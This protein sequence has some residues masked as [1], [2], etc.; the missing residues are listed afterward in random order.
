MSGRDIAFAA[1]T[2]PGRRLGG[3]AAPRTGRHTDEDRGGPGNFLG[4]LDPGRLP[5]R[6]PGA[7]LCGRCGYR[8]AGNCTLPA[9]QGRGPGGGG[10]GRRRALC[11]AGSL[12][13]PGRRQR[14]GQGDCPDLRCGGGDHHRHGSPARLCCGRVGTPAG[15]RCDRARQGQGDLL[16]SAAGGEHPRLLPLGLC[17]E[18]PRRA[19]S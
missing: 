9:E 2:D 10:C 5:D 4:E 11:C 1:F 18:R 13:A 14:S 12:R 6:L 3:A 16:P 15:V 8:C 7:G 17:Q 19:C